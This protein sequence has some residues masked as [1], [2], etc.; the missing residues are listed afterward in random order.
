MAVSIVGLLNL[1][2]NDLYWHAVLSHIS[3]QMAC[4]SFAFYCV[5]LYITKKHCLSIVKDSPIPLN[6]G[7]PLPCIVPEHV[8]LPNLEKRWLLWAGNWLLKKTC[9]TKF[10]AYFKKSRTQPI[11]NDPLFSTRQCQWS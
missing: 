9:Q 6:F 7:C 2:G 8:P 10:Q 1:T 5:I 11:P 4:L 3:N